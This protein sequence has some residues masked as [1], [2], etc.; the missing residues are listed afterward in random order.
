MNIISFSMPPNAW[1]PAEPDQYINIVI[2][3][4]IIIAV[5]LFVVIYGTSKGNP[6]QDI[7]GGDSVQNFKKR[8]KN[9]TY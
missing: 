1:K 8:N 3:T 5:I 6:K 7:E 9:K 2:G 4:T